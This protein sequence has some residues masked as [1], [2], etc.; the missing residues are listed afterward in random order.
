MDNTN[1]SLTIDLANFQKSL[2]TAF[3]MYQTTVKAMGSGGK[4]SLDQLGHA[5]GGLIAQ[6]GKSMTLRADAKPMVTAVLNAE[7]AVVKLGDSIKQAGEKS[8]SWLARNR[9]GLGQLSLTYSGMMNVYND[10][11]RLFGGMIRQQVEAEQGMARVGAAVRSTGNAAGYTAEQ[12]KAMAE[13]WEGSLAIDADEIMNQVTT[14]LLTFT[15]VSGAVFEEAQLQIMNMSRALG[16]DLQGAA[17]QV[18]KALQDP[19]EGLAALRRSGVSFSDEQQEVIKSLYETGQAV[20]AQRMIL[21]E[22]NKE[23][24]GQAAAFAETGGGKLAALKISFDNLGESIGGLLL[25]VIAGLGKVLGPLVDWFSGLNGVTKAAIVLTPLAT[26]AWYAFATSNVAAGVAS[27][28]LTVAITAASAAVKGFLTSIGPV[29]WA[30]MGIG[31][32]VTAYGV[33]T[34]KAK[35]DTTEL[36]EAQKTLAEAQQIASDGQDKMRESQ[37]R[38]REESGKSVSTFDAL[39]G[40]LEVLRNHSTMTA[41]SKRE[42]KGVVAELNG[43]YGQFLGN[44]NLETA[45]W[46]DV[47][48]ALNSARQQL[49]SYYVAKQTNEQFEGMIQTYT[50]GLAKLRDYYKQNGMDLDIYANRAT[51]WPKLIQTGPVPDSGAG[52]QQYQNKQAEIAVANYYI[53]K[54]NEL[55]VRIETEMPEYQQA[56]SMMFDFGGA[57]LGGGGSGAA[58]GPAAAVQNNLE[59]VREFLVNY[60][61]SEIERITAEFA[62]KRAV[63]LA[64][65]KKD[66]EEQV[67]L[68][69]KLGD[70]E[71]AEKQKIQDKT[72]KD[73]ADADKQAA[74]LRAAAQAAYYEEVQFLDAGYYEWKLKQI[75]TDVAAQ[76]LSA[77]QTKIATDKKVAELDKE[78]AAWEQLPLEGVLARYEKIKGQMN[79]TATVGAGAW[80]VVQ[81]GLVALKEELL[82]FAAIPGVD[83]ILAKLQVDIDAAAAKSAGKGGN[84]F[85]NGVVGFDPDDEKDKEKLSTLKSTFMGLQSQIQGVLSSALNLNQ[86]KRDSELEAI[87]E[88]ADK[89]R[90][91]EA[92]LLE[93]KQKIN[94]KYGAEERKLKRLQKAMSI[95]QA[96]INTAEGMTKAFTLGPILGPIMAALIGALGAAQINIIRQQKFALGGLFRGRGGPQEDAN[97]I[98]ISDGEYIVNAAATKR[99]RPVLDAL[100]F[101]VSPRVSGQLAFAGGGMVSGGSAGESGGLLRRLIEKVEILNMN[102]VKKELAVSVAVSG[103][104]EANIKAQDKARVKM[105]RRGYDQSLS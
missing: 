65:T 20:E 88:V 105:T 63:I 6:A 91:S 7:N 17:M 99:Y 49:I 73:L 16:T 48:T 74:D 39:I 42:L 44:I 53:D 28:G 75:D 55:K 37:E 22:L 101:G 83:V 33:A 68:L 58:G 89:Q 38:N 82:A 35:K 27:G 18:G 11:T 96:I 64:E 98:R 94:Q 95:G 59:S 43:K 77:E 78:K 52:L 87:E 29:G 23:F 54:L 3:N 80:K 5:L 15:Q 9:E 104:I 71:A 10:V 62:K 100:N 26:A 61:K 8:G 57:P 32:A 51:P 34:S 2:T 30:I 4:Q 102:L 103:D 1:I 13:G 14:P 36:G 41:E 72:D 45:A 90:W 70:V 76:Q 47:A 56:L 31:A 66:S 60:G 46:N 67:N 84:W 86:Q 85:W 79:D 50:S 97:T 40:K 92:K 19:V 93:E 12:L 24:G 81:D 69:K 25:P 21:A